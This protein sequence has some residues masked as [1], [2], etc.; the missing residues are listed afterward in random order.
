MGRMGQDGVE[1]DGMTCSVQPHTM[2]HSAQ[3]RLNVG[4]LQ[5]NEFSRKLDCHRHMDRGGGGGGVA[6]TV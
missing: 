2:Y 4:T 3:V 6:A 1:L 5:M